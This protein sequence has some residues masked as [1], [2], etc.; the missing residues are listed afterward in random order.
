[1]IVYFLEEG[2]M[3][4]KSKLTEQMSEGQVE[5]AVVA[6]AVEMT[7]TEVVGDPDIEKL[8]KDRDSLAKLILRRREL[9]NDAANKKRLLEKKIEDM[10]AEAVEQAKRKRFDDFPRESGFALDKVYLLA[11]RAI[12]AELT[13]SDLEEFVKARAALKKSSTPDQARPSAAVEL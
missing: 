1:M 3:A 7:A 2:A 4:R 10:K 13:L 12:A 8:E 9:A 11:K 6:D 5:T